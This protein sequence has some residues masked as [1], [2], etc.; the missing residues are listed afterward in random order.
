MNDWTGR[1]SPLVWNWL[2]LPLISSIF[3]LI[4]L[5]ASACGMEGGMQLG[6]QRYQCKW[7]LVG[8]ILIKLYMPLVL[9]LL[10]LNFNL[11][12]FLL[13]CIIIF[14]EFV[15]S[16]TW[17]LTINKG[18]QPNK[19]PRHKVKWLKST[20]RCYENQSESRVNEQRATNTFIVLM[21]SKFS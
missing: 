7:P 3:A 14:L 2:V 6:R 20:R 11:L 18:I 12:L 21:G 4:D 9:L 16:H 13:L 17:S 10:L 19:H 15:F 5:L 1:S 8:D